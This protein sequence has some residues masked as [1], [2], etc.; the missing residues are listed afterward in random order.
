MALE[1]NELN[2]FAKQVSGR[3]ET[4]A[5]AITGNFFVTLNAGSLMPRDVCAMQMRN[6]Q[7]VIKA[8]EDMLHSTMNALEYANVAGMRAVG[9]AA[10]HDALNDIALETIDTISR[11]MSYNVNKTNNEVTNILIQ[12]SSRR[13]RQN[14]SREDAIAGAIRGLEFK[15]QDRIGRQWVPELFVNN[16]VKKRMIDLYVGAFDA[17]LNEG[18]KVKLSDGSIVNAEEFGSIKHKLFHPNAS[19]LPVSIE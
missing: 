9:H 18:S 17:T 5:S 7:E 19:L 12:A 11:Q 6:A 3:Y 10:S 2:R 13:S 8:K 1:L 4:F 15:F 16:L 14:I